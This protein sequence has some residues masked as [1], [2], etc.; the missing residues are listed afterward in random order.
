MHCVAG[1]S[2]SPTVTIAYLMKM[3]KMSFSD[4]LAHVKVKRTSILIYPHI[5][6]KHIH[7]HPYNHTYT[8][9]LSHSH[10]LSPLI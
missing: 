9:T 4:A 5:A 10:L 3:H 2:R 6:Y 1:I 7:I 8:H